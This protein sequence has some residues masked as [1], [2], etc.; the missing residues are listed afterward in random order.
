MNLEIVYSVLMNSRLHN[1]IL[2]CIINPKV[3][4]TSAT[5]VIMIQVAHAKQTHI[6]YDF[7]FHNIFS[8]I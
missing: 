7:N 1:N 4:N 2:V 8:S 3:N 5:F 6:F